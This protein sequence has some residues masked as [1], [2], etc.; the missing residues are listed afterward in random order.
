MSS[1]SQ[2]NG[3]V[4][5][6]NPT[7]TLNMSDTNS[8]KP[9]GSN[10]IVLNPNSASKGS[11]IKV[12]NNEVN[13]SGIENYEN[14]NKNNNYIYKELLFLILIIFLILFLIYILKKKS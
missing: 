11:L 10:N 1:I 14:Y 12:Q 3:N 7:G 6:M 2:V 8:F 13:C 5:G 9:N 4:I